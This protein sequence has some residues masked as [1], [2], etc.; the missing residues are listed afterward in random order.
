[1]FATW[2]KVTRRPGD[3]VSELRATLAA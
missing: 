1:V 2:A 3:L